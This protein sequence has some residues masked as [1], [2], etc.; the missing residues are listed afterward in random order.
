MN[1][2]QSNKNYSEM[3]GQILVKTRKD[4]HKC[5]SDEHRLCPSA[6]QSCGTWLEHC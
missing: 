4:L 6:A 3:K 2:E 5:N 1:I